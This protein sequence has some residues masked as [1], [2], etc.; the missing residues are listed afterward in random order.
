[1]LSSR[2]GS[3]TARE[4][5]FQRGQLVKRSYRGCIRHQCTQ[6]DREM[7][8]R[9]VSGAPGAPGI[10]A[11]PYRATK[12]IYLIRHGNGYHNNLKDPEGYKS[13]DLADAHLTQ[14]GWAQA[15]EVNAHLIKAKVKPQLVVTS[16]LRRTLETAAGCFGVLSEEGNGAA[17]SDV[18]MNEMKG[19]GVN[20]TPH[21]AIGRPAMPVVALEVCR[22][23]LGVHPC[24]ARRSI[25]KQKADFPG[26]NFDLIDSYRGSENNSE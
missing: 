18:L 4:K 6:R 10:V 22:E 7:E 24:D 2:R 5:R 17:P 23:T 8:G 21:A 20:V 3:S 15:R 14:L 11:T 12:V 26:V 13:W 16:P 1:M 19:N 25:T 9:G